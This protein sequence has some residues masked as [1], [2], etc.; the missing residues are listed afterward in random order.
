VL[1]LLVV[2]CCCSY[3]ITQCYGWK[4]QE[5]LNESSL[6]QLLSSPELHTLLLLH[7]AAGVQHVRNLR[8]A[9][10]QQQEEGSS[11]EADDASAGSEDAAE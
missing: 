2:F 11:E 5:W 3:A 10:Q 6:V 7:A 8:A 9:K 4:P 1:L